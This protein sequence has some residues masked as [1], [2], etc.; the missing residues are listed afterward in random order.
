MD[1]HWESLPY[2]R[3]LRIRGHNTMDIYIE[4]REDLGARDSIDAIIDPG[5]SY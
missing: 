3:V 1:H 2:P 5:F 4:G